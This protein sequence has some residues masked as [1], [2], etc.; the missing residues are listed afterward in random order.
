M[1]IIF[2]DEIC[3]PWVRMPN[4]K[5][6]TFV[7]KM[8]AIIEKDFNIDFD[9]HIKKY[10]RYDLN[11]FGKIVEGAY[12]AS[13]NMVD[14]NRIISPYTYTQRFIFNKHDMK[15]SIYKHLFREMCGLDYILYRKLKHDHYSICIDFNNKHIIYSF[16]TEDIVSCIIQLDM[17]NYE[18]H[19]LMPI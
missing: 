10:V 19:D 4:N 12:I 18:K 14:K 9:I 16:A 8:V 1:K 3:K 17:E 5:Y 6:K 15:A 11:H 2:D 7:D 13:V